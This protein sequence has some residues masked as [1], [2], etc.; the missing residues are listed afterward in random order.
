MNLVRIITEEQLQSAFKIR[1]EVFVK[2]QGVPK[3]DEY[4]K[5]DTLQENCVHMLLIVKNQPVGTARVREVDGTGKLERICILPHMRNLGL[6]KEIV[7]YLEKIAIDMGLTDFKLHAQTQAQVFYGKLGYKKD[8][9]VFIEDGIP[10]VL[11]KKTV[12]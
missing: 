2:E 6:G 3:D 5:Y 8:S 4:D 11:M 9:E 12:R 1:E 10:H 7:T